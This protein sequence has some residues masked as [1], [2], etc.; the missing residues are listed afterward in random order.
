MSDFRC[1]QSVIRMAGMSLDDEH[2]YEYDYDYEHD[3]DY[4]YDYEHDYEHE[5]ETVNQRTGEPANIERNA[6]ERRESS[7]RRPL[8]ILALAEL[9]AMTAWFSAT[10]VAPALAA[11]WRLDDAGMAWLT[12]SVQLGFVA[13][14][15]AAALLNLADRIP[16]VRLFAASAL[17]AA[18]ATAL[19]ALLE[20][21]FTAAVA[22]RMLTG[23][24]LAGVYPVGMKLA[25]SWT[26]ANRGLGIGLL[27]GALTVGSGAPHLLPLAG[28]LA[29]WRTALYLAAAT[30]A[31]GGVIA[32]AWLREGPLAAPSP[33]FQWRYAFRL[34]RDREL[35]LANLGYLGHMWELYAMWAWI[36]LYLRESFDMSGL[37]P[38]W[39]NAAAFAVIAAG[40]IGSL[41]AG[42]LA[43]RRG[44]TAV[45]IAAMAASGACALAAGPL[46]GGPPALVLALA[47][48]W[49]TTVVADSAQFSAAVTELADPAYAGTALTVQTCAGFLLTAASIRL[50]PI[51]TARWGWTAAFAAL[52]AGPVLGVAAMAAL[53]RAPGAR[54]LAGGRR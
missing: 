3:Y 26:R 48:V 50:V 36:P 22:L 32:A 17:A 47:L 28:G 44:R 14:T 46:G 15:L 35:R 29:D 30:T 1:P 4:D 2:D 51:L 49:G 33:P 43:D 37:D 21:G 6:S 53:R 41:A 39:A 7:A 34:W 38:R 54:R 16:A 20:P 52:A 24:A 23:A 9:L 13:G 18:A 27:V 8:V 31:A 25:A 19:V 40:G 45:T 11:D 10:A 5:R 42:A 12:L